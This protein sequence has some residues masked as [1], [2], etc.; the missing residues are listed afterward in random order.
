MIGRR[1]FLVGGIIGSSLAGSLDGR[2]EAAL[3]DAPA[4]EQVSGLAPTP[5]MGWN[6]WI[7]FRLKVTEKLMREQAEPLV[8][9]GM[10]D[11]GYE[12]F[13]IDGGWEGYHDARGV[14]QPNHQKFPDM[15]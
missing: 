14:F 12:Y 15:K 3:A 10:K 4:A 1:D 8:K 2:G 13:V 5:P 9:S 11:A 7:P 6:S